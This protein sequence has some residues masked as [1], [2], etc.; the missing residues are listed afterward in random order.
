MNLKS[1]AA[2]LFDYIVRIMFRQLSLYAQIVKFQRQPSTHTC[3]SCGC[4]QS[5]YSI[6]LPLHLNTLTCGKVNIL[7]KSRR[8]VQ[9]GAKMK[10]NTC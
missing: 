9:A 3:M 4:L 5:T 8:S 10:L 7:V 1:N 6:C 2:T